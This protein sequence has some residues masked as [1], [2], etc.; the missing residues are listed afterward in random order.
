M[1][2]C[3]DRWVS[4]FAAADHAEQVAHRGNISA[5]RGSIAQG[6]DALVHA[7]LQLTPAGKG[8]TELKEVPP[9]WTRSFAFFL[10]PR[11]AVA[12]A[13]RGQVAQAEAANAVVIVELKEIA[14]PRVE[15]HAPAHPSPCA[16]FCQQGWVVVFVA[17]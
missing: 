2:G 5:L 13:D 11:I 9:T 12:L 16:K 15:R 4:A 14:A 6:A 8:A 3:R 17:S 1:T 10:A 7:P